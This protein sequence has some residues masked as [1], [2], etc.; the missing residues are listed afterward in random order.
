MRRLII[1]LVVAFG[2][3]TARAADPPRKI[4]SVEGV[5]EYRL[6]NGARVLL[7]PEG[8]RPTITVNM[9]VLVG[10][11]HEGYGEAGMAH[12]LEHMVFKGTPTFPNVPKAIK[13][14]GASFNGTTNVDRTNY[15]ETL[16]ASDE[17]LEFG[18]KLESDRLVNSFV[19]REDLASEMSVVRN[20]FEIGENSPQRVLSERV[21][22]AAY[23]WHNYG[24]TTIGNRSDIERVPI[25][26]LQAFYKKYYQPDNCVLI[27]A[28]KFEEA[29]ALALCEKY[30]GSIPKPQR[31]LTESWTEEPPQDGERT[32]VLRRVG[33]VG[34]MVVA[35]HIPSASHEDWA[36]LSV[37][38]GLLTQ[39]PDGRLAKALIE[40]K[41]ATG[42]NGS[43][44]NNHDPGLFTVSAQFES[45]QLEAVRDVLLE[46][47]ENLGNQPFTKEEVEKARVRGRRGSETRQADSG[48]MSQALSS[49]SALGD[50]R[51][52]FLQR[53][54]L[55]AV[56]AEDVNRVANT[57]FKKQNRT[58]GVYTPEDKPQRLAIPASPKIDLL[59][60]DYQGGKVAEAVEAFD[61]SPANLDAQTKIVDLGGVKAGLLPK[62]T[63][64]ETVSMVLTLHYGNEESLKDQTAV[65]A[66]LPGLM[67]AGTKSHDRQALREELEKLGVRITPGMGGFGGGGGRRGGGG[68]GGAATP[69]Q[70]TFSVEAKRSTLPA[71]LQ[72]L[73]EILRE[74]SF[75]AAEFDQMK[76]G[77]RAGGREAATDPRQL[78]TI[79]LGRLLAPYP[80]TDIR[81][82]PTRE[83]SEKRREAVTLDQVVALYNKQL[84]ATVGEIGIVGDFDPE[85]TLPLLR[86]MLKDWKSDVPVKR[87][88]RVA[89]LDVKPVHEEIPTPDKENAVFLAGLTF[90]LK[91]S[92]PDYAALRMG[93]YL[94]G[95]DTLS[96]RLGVRIRQQ[97]GISYGATSSLTVSS[98]DPLATFMVSVNLAP[99]NIDKAETAVLEV[100]TDFVEKGPSATE[101]ADG[102]KSFLESQKLARTTDAGLAGQITTN[103]QLGR[104]FAHTSDLEKQI[105]A[106]TPEEVRDT[107][108][109]YVNPK[110]LVI[111][112][113]G[114]FCKK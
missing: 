101:L 2:A 104:K 60:K 32:V 105:A 44:G 75:P 17:N 79:R 43:A 86:D 31:K 38:A 78:A 7:Y 1:L 4:A 81:Y 14:H 87:I 108:R 77:G 24:K 110:N 114:D 66:M 36:P 69:G 26:N 83:E 48:A 57:Y 63:R 55:A 19:K 34:S 99:Q 97:L 11:R 23:A 9:T 64:G 49:A 67:V 51:L 91:E 74:P 111:I 28:G 13:D 52:H 29:K 92:D 113:A 88:E 25:D 45:G 59:V 62:K 30:L 47:M 37:L 82:S 106:L 71:A 61:T 89:M 84:G 41:K 73:K 80:P 98:R 107:F 95:N 39:R 53:D 35:Y 5:T 12:L 3:T 85:A 103:L 8:S 46:T 22:A 90:R 102:K 70:L 65:A 16:P 42:V 76:R 15:F 93:N 94:L 10:S 56:T 18:I 50:W 100:M 72:L 27:V 54:R 6:S 96:A 58:V 109:K 20:E 68:G 40:S 112:R 33:T 21:H